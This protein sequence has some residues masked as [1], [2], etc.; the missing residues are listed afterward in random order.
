LIVSD[1][2]KLRKQLGII[3]FTSLT[4][5]SLVRR[6]TVLIRASFLENLTIYTILKLK[7]MNKLLTLILFLTLVVGS[8]MQ[9]LSQVQGPVRPLHLAMPKNISG[10]MVTYT[11]SVSEFSF[12]QEA[13]S[14]DEMPEQE[15]ANKTGQ[16]IDSLSNL[17]VL[18]PPPN[19]NCSS[20]LNAANT[21]VPGGNYTCG[22]LVNATVEAGEYTGCFTPAPI[23]TVWYSFI[24]DQP[25]MWVSVKPSNATC[26]SVG[27]VVP[28]SFGIAVYRYTGSCF[29]GLANQAAG[30]C[31]NYY[32]A[33]IAA[34]NL[35]NLSK[36][37]LTGLVPLQTYVIQ[38]AIYASC[39]GATWKPFCIKIGHPS[40]CTTCANIC[41]PMCVA[42]PYSP[43]PT[44]ALVNY[45]T[46]NCPGYPWSPPS[47]L[48]EI[49]T[50]C[51]S[52]TA[53]N[54]TQY[55]QTI[56][57]SS[58]SGGMLSFNYTLYNDTCGFMSAG[59]VFV[60]NGMITPLNVGTTYRICYTWQ[61]ACTMDSSLW[62]FAY[63]PSTSLPVTLMSWDALQ[64]KNKVKL[65][66]TTASEENSKE[67]VIERMTTKEDFV[68]IG[69]IKGAGT[70]TSVHSYMS[71]DEHP[72]LGTNFYRL[73]QVDFNGKSA[74]TKIIAVRFTNPDE[75][76]LV[77]P[78]PILDKA[79]VTF[80]TSETSQALLSVKDLRGKEIFH[81][82][83][84]S[85]SG[86][87]HRYLDMSAFANGV[88]FVQLIVDDQCLNAK[89][90]KK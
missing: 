35:S 65:V 80:H 38:V 67:F 46:A 86:E 66:W 90:I 71:F 18:P 60:N 77:I 36:V 16:S 40:T 50:N 43:P 70:S 41:G 7:V 64:Y 57:Y 4:F 63:T 58:C 56:V 51:F 83:F 15:N 13:N 3:P 89:V 59:S 45:V 76:M 72:T 53:A 88:Y 47:N 69:R 27:G 6:S 28:S 73:K 87:N 26:G 5:T 54:D 25:T 24:A 68:E 20:A 10:S 34:G 74:H 79:V 39:T 48:G 32:N 9:A 2:Y 84:T 37:N 29:P 30:G 23:G 42:A 19:D 75:N 11:E 22:T 33:N 31:T 52:F 61:P 62:P 82:T 55:L 21:L 78:N 14:T 8:I 85:P 81:E 1:A 44:M 17:S 12:A 49:T